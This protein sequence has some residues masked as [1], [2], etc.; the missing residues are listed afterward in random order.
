MKRVP[1]SELKEGALT[2]HIESVEVDI[3]VSVTAC[4]PRRGT[5]HGFSAASIERTSDRPG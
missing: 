2:T 1:L 4:T 3:A 5:P